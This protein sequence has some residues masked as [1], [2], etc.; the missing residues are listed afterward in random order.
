MVIIATK[1]KSFKLLGKVQDSGRDALSPSF[2]DE[3][4]PVSL[5]QAALQFLR[6]LVVGPLMYAKM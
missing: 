1:T 2:S 4:H 6:L 3:P 5:M